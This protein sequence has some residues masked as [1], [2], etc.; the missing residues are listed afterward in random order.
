M[1]RPMTISSFFLDEILH[2][3]CDILIAMA[4]IPGVLHK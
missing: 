3:Y 2:E 1:E 4:M